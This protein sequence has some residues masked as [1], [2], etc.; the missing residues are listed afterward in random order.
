MDFIISQNQLNVIVEQNSPNDI[1]DNLRKLYDFT[2]E[3]IDKSMSVWG[4]NAK[5]LI[6]WGAALGGMV[7]PLK[8]WLETQNFEITKEQTF[9]LLLGIACNY[10]YDNSDFI[11]KVM[12]K[13]KDEGLLDIFKK[14]YQKSE[15]LKNGLV[16]F[17]R[18]LKIFGDSMTSI[19][20]YAFVLP[21]LGDIYQMVG[22]EDIFESAKIISQRIA[23]SGVVLI[24]GS[25][26]TSFIEKILR[27]TEGKL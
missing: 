5:F 12:Q 17:L 9:L 10:Y 23:A 20:S 14:L 2:R 11:R 21:I 16:E 6:T 7:L 22:G 25:S 19:M 18:S 1:T 4:L 15:E 26:L 3:L 24:V 8:I 27:L 13:I